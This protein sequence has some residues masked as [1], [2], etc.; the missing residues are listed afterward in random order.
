MLKSLFWIRPSSARVS[1][2]LMGWLHLGWWP[3]PE[4]RGGVASTVHGGAASCLSSS[5]VREG[6]ESG[7]EAPRWVEGLSLDIGEGRDSPQ[8]ELHVGGL[9]GEGGTGERPKKQ[10]RLEPE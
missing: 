2:S 10:Q 5:V 7:R 3:N 6:G 9:L 8:D 4:Y 1:P